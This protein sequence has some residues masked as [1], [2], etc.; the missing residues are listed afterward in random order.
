MYWLRV[1]ML[2]FCTANDAATPVS[3]QTYM[4]ASIS[5]FQHSPV[6]NSFIPN[7]HMWAVHTRTTMPLNVDLQLC[8]VLQKT[9]FAKH[10]AANAVLTC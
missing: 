6:V 2:L 10:N 8:K 5:S 4:Y 7:F 3:P 9:H 1:Q